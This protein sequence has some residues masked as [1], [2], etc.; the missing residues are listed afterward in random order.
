MRP[1]LDTEGAAA[2]P[3]VNGEIVFDDA[4]QSR[5]FATTMAACD[6]GLIDYESFRPQLIAQI[7]RRDTDGTGLHAATY[8][9][10]WQD[11]FEALA[12]EVGL[13]SPAEIDQRAA[14]F[15]THS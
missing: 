4:W 3:R 13:V 1:E 5:V 8:W 14:A 12:L 2:P 15:A 9:E 6:A 11:A 7:A 10:A